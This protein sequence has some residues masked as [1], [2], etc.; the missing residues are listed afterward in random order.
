MNSPLAKNF[1]ALLEAAKGRKLAVAGH[2]RPDGDCVG[3]QFA[4]AEILEAAGADVVCVNR[5]EIPYLY[6]NFCDKPFLPADSLGEERDIVLVDCSD[7]SRVS[8]ALAARNPRIFACVDHHASGDSKARINVIDIRAGATAE[9]I[10]LCASELG[11]NISAKSANLL[12]VGLATDT[13][14]FTTSSTR[15]ESF[16]AARALL[17]FGAD[18]NYAAQQLYQR[19]RA[20]KMRLL[21]EYLASLKMF[22]GG[23][24]CVG[25]IPLGTFER[26]GS[27][28]EDTDGLVDFARSIEGVEI[29]ATLEELAGGSVKGSLRGRNPR[30]RVDEVA[31][32]FGGGGHFAAAGFTA[33]NETFETILPKLLGLFESSLERK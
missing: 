33:H 9:I 4:L 20:P 5:D 32:A 19:E 31:A 8:P 13:R 22:G 25:F 21:S 23:K 14:Q 15:P 3:S 30:Y 17:G 6:A 1:A 26:T 16:E 18:A 27:R 28:K 2:M 12:Y 24:I 11:L 10:A 29:A 7:L